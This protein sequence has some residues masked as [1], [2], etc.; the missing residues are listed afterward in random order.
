M[1]AA[2]EDEVLVVAALAIDV[3]LI[4]AEVVLDEE[5]IGD[6]ECWWAIDCDCWCDTDDEWMELNSELYIVLE[7]GFAI[8]V[9]VVV[10]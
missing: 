7:G 10:L 9:I 3:E 5:D 6:V 4:I 8:A 1:L 2:C